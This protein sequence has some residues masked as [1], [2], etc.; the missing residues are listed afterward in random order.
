MPY[1]LAGVALA[2]TL[3][4]LFLSNNFAK[5]HSQALAEHVAWDQRL[6]EYELLAHLAGLTN[7]PGN[8]LFAHRDVRQARRELREA[9][10]NLS[11]AFEKVEQD[12]H[13]LEPR[14][15]R[16]RVLEMLEQVKEDAAH[17][18]QTSQRVILAFEQED[19]LAAG[20]A[21][22]AMDR[23]YM[24]LSDSM[25]R[26]RRTVRDAQHA[27][28]QAQA[29]AAGAM[30]RL[31]I[32]AAVLILATILIAAHSTYREQLRIRRQR[33]D[34]TEHAALI[35]SVFNSM[36]DAIVMIDAAGII[37]KVNPAV[38]TLLG[39]GADE[40][41]GQNVTRLMFADDAGAHAEYIQRYFDTG[42]TRVL[43][44]GREVLGRHRNG[45]QV[46]LHLN[47]TRVDIGNRVLFTGILRNMADQLALRAALE[48][49][50][51]R[52]EAATREKSMFL[53]TMSHEI[54][55]PMNGVV[56]MI[57][58]LLGTDLSPAQR[59]YLDAANASALTLVELISD[60]LDLSKIEAG[61]L[62][63][64]CIEFDLTSMLEEVVDLFSGRALRQRLRLHAEIDPDCPRRVRGDPI[65]V[66]QILLNF[67][68]NAVKFTERGRVVLRARWGAAQPGGNLL[69]L[70]VEDTGP[71]IPLESQSAIFEAF[72]QADATTTRQFGGT[73]L[74]LTIC[75]ELSR[76]M[77]GEL[78][79][80][81][82]P[83]AG[84]RFWVKLPL[85]AVEPEAEALAPLAE[86]KVSI[87]APPGAA[88]DS[89]V[90]CARALGAT[91]QA[92]DSLGV[93]GELVW[94]DP[95][96]FGAR[97]Y[98]VQE[99]PE[100]CARLYLAPECESFDEAAQRALGYD[101]FVRTPLSRKR[102]AKAA[103]H[104]L[105]HRARE[106]GGSIDSKLESSLRALG[107][108]RTAA[109]AGPAALPAG[110]RVLVAE[111]N[112]T[113]QIIAQHMLEKLGCQ[114]VV[115][116][117]GIE[118]LAQL[119]ESAFDV[120]LMDCQMPALNGY[121]ATRQLRQL[122]IENAS[123]AVIALTASA[124]AGDREKCLE[125]GMDDYLTKPI[126]MGELRAGL[127]RCLAS[128]TRRAR[129]R[130]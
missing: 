83:G 50:K 25:H 44:I 90:A 63:L 69:M 59:E 58:L 73:G 1:V 27:D 57:E 46:P 109:A 82:T 110:L 54:R 67:L 42:I 124:V 36:G 120:V 103:L 92:S 76:R 79:L 117:D 60:I 5:R 85:E 72:T 11:I 106:S 122:P 113:N 128:Q 38:S 96:E 93:P 47:V 7:L 126:S 87:V 33:L 32:E 61:R 19:E 26:L 8:E 53:A 129:R 28:L 127:A 2:M 17:H 95:G 116:A 35:E 15:V 99:L 130:Y 112:P 118:A 78:G 68:S 14:D 12:A 111:D 29:D 31:V 97:P 18:Q 40:L 13:R 41:L 22:A 89:A 71:G 21:M 121:E 43:S 94:V 107:P 115:A 48:A 52:A 91:V 119:T 88:R 56:G 114:V 39:Y 81:S 84:S 100:S 16:Q 66:R 125:A 77:N 10:E 6:G 3:G 75:C 23:A 30:R 123:I 34:I 101:A 37:R 55:T 45:S 70:E 24:E 62:E 20:S 80:E 108:D 104:A 49:E 86:R 64:D 65:R 9:V 74:G 4:M 51:E 98:S 105:Y 102:A